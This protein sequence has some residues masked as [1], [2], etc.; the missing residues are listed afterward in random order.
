MDHY[1]PGFKAGGPIPSVSRIIEMADQ[2]EFRVVTRD[3]DLGDLESFPDHQTHRTKKV[4]K[5]NVYYINSKLTDWL[6]VRKQTLKWRPAAYYFNSAHS[7]FSSLIP[8]AL[9]KFRVLPKAQNVIVAPRGEFGAGAL[10]LK[11]RKKSTFKPVIRWLIPP[12]VTWHASHPGEVDQ[13]KSWWGKS[14]PLTHTF[15][16]ALDPAVEPAQQASTGPTNQTVFTFASRIDRMKGLD[17]A[18]RIIEVAGREIPFAWSIQGSVTD[19]NYLLEIEEQLTQLP[20]SVTVIRKE[21]FSPDA[22]QDIFSQATAFVFPTLGEN[23]GHVIAEALSVGCPVF[24]TA[25]TPWTELITSGAGQIIIS[26]E[27]TAAEL[28][29]LASLTLAEQKILRVR[30]HTIYKQW[31]EGH[32]QASNPFSAIYQQS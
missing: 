1:L 12:H 18:N 14:Q 28:V 27:Q 24:V 2:C 26:D 25:N 4:G 23:F 32:K 9:I 3:R 10:S 17:R 21:S 31:F 20:S 15:V 13:I 22:S 5:A 29:T 16:V 19:S 6:W 7:L 30:V 8:L 11:S